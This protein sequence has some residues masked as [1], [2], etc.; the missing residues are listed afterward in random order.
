MDEWWTTRTSSPAPTATVPNLFIAVDCGGTEKCDSRWENGE[1][2]TIHSTYYHYN[3][4]IDLLHDNCRKRA[5]MK[6]RCERDL[7]VEAFSNA[8]RAVTGRGQSN[9]ALNGL[10]LELQ[11]DELRVTG[12]DGSLTITVR[13]PVSGEGDG[14]ALVPARLLSDV[15]RSLPAGAVTVD[16][17][18]E[19]ARISAGRSKFQL[20]TLEVGQYPVFAAP[21]SESV[22]LDATA[23]AEALKQVVSAASTEESLQ[24]FTGVLMAAE[25]DGLSL[26]ATDRYRLSV[27]TLSG[28]SVLREGQQ[29]I[30]P[31]NALRELLRLAGTA[32]SVVLRLGEKDVTFEVGD[33]RITTQLLEGSFPAYG[34]LIPKVHPNRLTVNR[35]E[36]ME[37]LRRVKLLAKESKDSKAVQ[38]VMTSDSVSLLAQNTEMGEATEV[39]DARLEGEDL[40]VAFN[41]EY[42]IGGLEVCPGEEVLLDTIDAMKPAL[43]RSGETPDF[44]YL[45][46]PI[47]V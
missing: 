8:N 47:R 4:S 33:V 21:A 15:V 10:R 43:L 44:L 13:V 16:V 41:P 22:S 17:D 30:V 20:L 32:E 27:R 45:L 38:L 18:A 12:S 14:V 1:S 35:T 24:I 37:A 34:D 3:L 40:T 26:A 28:T 7:L 11:G 6:F 19:Q 2:S 29:V 5:V 46:M 42:L 36:L 31:S 9:T 23:F 25:S 39:V